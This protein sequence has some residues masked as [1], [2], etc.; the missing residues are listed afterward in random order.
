MKVLAVI[1]ARGGSKGIPYK[2][3]APLGGRPLLAWTIEAALKAVGVDRVVVSTDDAR[4]AEVARAKGAEVPFVRP[5]ELAGDTAPAL[6]VMR[7]ALDALAQAPDPWTAD[8]VAYLQPTSPFRNHRHIERAVDLLKSNPSADTV[9]SVV[10]VPHNMQPASLMRSSNGVLE[11]L[12]PEDERRFRRQDKR[13][14][15]V[16][17]NGP[18]LLLLRSS[19]VRSGRLYGDTILPLEMDRLHSL[20]I[21]EPLDME[22]AERL[23]PLVAR[24]DA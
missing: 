13:D 9:V 14:E 8:V 19:V 10:R 17:R 15:M 2:N 1:P 24:S 21:D 18:A 7:H 16:A 4:I 20:D 12:V 11:F 3:I 23:L 6:P 5:A 22:V